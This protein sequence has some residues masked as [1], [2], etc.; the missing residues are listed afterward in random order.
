MSGKLSQIDVHYISMIKKSIF[1]Y[2]D[3]HVSTDYNC[4]KLR[5]P[6]A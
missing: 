4:P 5:K 3:A 6:E 1:H 2:I